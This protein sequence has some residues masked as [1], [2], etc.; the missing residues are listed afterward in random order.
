MK[1][2]R[3]SS[4]LLAG[5]V[6]L[7]TFAGCSSLG[8]GKLTATDGRF[9]LLK[10]FK[11]KKDKLPEF[12]TPQSMVAIWKASTFEKAGA[13]S[14]RGFGGR[15]YFYDANNKP[16][17]VNGDLTIYGYD[18]HNRSEAVD[19][20]ADRKFVFKAESLDSHFSESALGESYS[21]W[22]PWDNVGG[23]EKTITLIPVFKTVDGHMPEAKPATMRLPGRR[24]S[25]SS[26]STA[27]TSKPNGQVVQASAEFPISLPVGSNITSPIAPKKQT[28]RTPTTLRL[29]PHLAEQLSN[30]INRG[31]KDSGKDRAELPK[32]NQNTGFEKASARVEQSTEQEA[33]SAEIGRPRAASSSTVF[34]QPGAFR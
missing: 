11:G 24:T 25:K 6:L 21:F 7:V 17:R 23:E 8:T 19:G 5:A 9:N 16:V 29:T 30:S 13:K 18:D 10:R 27:S 14:I 28:R 2:T 31:E 33:R 34:G 20:K 26:G 12:K 4:W 1:F 15:F 32:E 22:V 3:S